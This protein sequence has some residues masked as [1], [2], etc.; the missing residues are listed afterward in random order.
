MVLITA[1]CMEVCSDSNGFSPITDSRKAFQMSR[2]KKCTARKSILK[3]LVH[4]RAP[5]YFILFLYFSNR[6]IK[7]VST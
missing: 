7:L 1:L 3:V 6:V 2:G 4:S 5:G